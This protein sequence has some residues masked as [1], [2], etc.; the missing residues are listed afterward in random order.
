MHSTDPSPAG[1]MPT[2]EQIMNACHAQAGRWLLNSE[3]RAIHELFAPTHWHKTPQ[4]QPQPQPEA[5]MP[6]DTEILKALNKGSISGMRALFAPVVAKAR[7]DVKSWKGC[8]TAAIEQRDYRDA[9]LAKCREE[10]AAAREQINTLADQCT[11]ARLERDQARMELETARGL[12]GEAANMLD[13]YKLTSF[14]HA[15]LERL[16]A[17]AEGGK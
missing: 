6:T 11:A 4:P 7:R 12:I 5:Q 13:S 3:I 1:D 14:A 9:E 2:G 17:F 16:R 8:F 10:L 15:L